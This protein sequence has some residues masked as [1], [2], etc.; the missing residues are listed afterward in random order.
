MGREAL[1][2]VLQDKKEC[3]FTHTTIGLEDHHIFFGTANRKLSEKRGLKV[4]LSSEYH[5]NGPNAVHKNRKTDLQLKEMAQQ[6]YEKHYGTRQ[7]FIEEFG[8]SYL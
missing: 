7:Q 1:K 5:R 8:K 4:W 6:Y 2:T 3:F